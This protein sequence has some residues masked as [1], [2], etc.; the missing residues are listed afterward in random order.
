MVWEKSYYALVLTV[1]IIIYE[2]LLVSL[3][4]PIFTSG[5]CVLLGILIGEV[6]LA[7]IY[8]VIF[9]HLAKTHGKIKKPYYHEHILGRTIDAK[10]QKFP[11]APY[12]PDRKSGF[13]DDFEA[14]NDD[15]IACIIEEMEKLE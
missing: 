15:D 7:I 3:L 14:L 13:Y 11:D 10:K 2:I 8:Y 12:L 9:R 1:G 4:E 5:L 6:T